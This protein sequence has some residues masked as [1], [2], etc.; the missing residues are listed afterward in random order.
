MKV[1][2]LVFFFNF[3][4]NIFKTLEIK[5]T[6]RHQVKPLLYNSVYINLVSLASTYY[7]LDSLFKGD[8]PVVI[9]FIAGSVSGKWFAMTQIEEVQKRIFDMRKPKNATLKPKKQ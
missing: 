5:Y 1:Y 2:L 7:S 3:A 4:F 6:Y 9:F 8:W